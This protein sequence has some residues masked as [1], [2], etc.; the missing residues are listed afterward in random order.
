MSYAP[1]ELLPEQKLEKKLEAKRISNIIQVNR[2]KVVKEKNLQKLRSD[3]FDMSSY[4]TNGNDIYGNDIY[5]NDIYE[6]E[7]GNWTTLSR[8]GEK[9]QHLKLLN[10]I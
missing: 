6:H 4:Y 1:F 10:K 7:R 9:Y 5:G 8:S 2:E 3:Y